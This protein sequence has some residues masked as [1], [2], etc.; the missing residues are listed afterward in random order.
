[1]SI[2]SKE[3]RRGL[4][5]IIPLGVVALLLAV[6]VERADSFAEPAAESMENAVESV[7]KS[8]SVEVDAVRLKPFNPNT[9]EYEELRAAG[10]SVEVAVGIV[11]WRRYGKVYRIKEDLALVN[12]VNDSIYAAL[13]PYIIIDS[14]LAPH[15]KYDKMESQRSVDSAKFQ[16]RKR[17]TVELQPFMIDTASAHYLYLLGFS[18][19]QAEVIER[20]VKMLG[21]LRSEAELRDCYVISDSMANRILP[22]VIFKQ[23][24]EFKP[25][26]RGLVDINTADTILLQSVYG[27]GA[28]SAHHIVRYRE[29][30][31]GYHS[32]EQLRELKCVTSEN[33]ARFFDK[34][35]CDSCKISKIDINFADPKSLMRHPYISLQALRRIVKHRQLKGGWSRIEEMVDDNILSEEEARRLAPYLRF[36]LRATEKESSEELPSVSRT[37]RQKERKGKDNPQESKKNEQE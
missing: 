27:I 3:E 8:D 7:M 6:L 5:W 22:Y 18:R 24:E 23:R 25:E 11:R 21:G 15:P 32:V 4:L 1:M 34:I 28:T 19:R 14:E 13:K 2:F 10:V 37:K 12:G 33:Y 29:L 36:R 35:Y 9:F 20:Y 31:G 17:E 30:L 16:R 26:E